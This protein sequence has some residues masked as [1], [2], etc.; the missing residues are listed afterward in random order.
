MVPAQ[1][2]SI[3][4]PITKHSL[5][6]WDR[7]KSPH[8][9]LLSFLNNPSFYPAWS[10]LS[11]FSAWSNAGLIRPIFF[12]HSELL[13]LF[14]HSVRCINLPAS[15]LFRYLQLKHLFSQTTPPDFT[16]PGFTT[17]ESSC[18]FDPHKRGLISDLYAHLFSHSKTSPPTYT[19]KWERDLNLTLERADWKQIWQST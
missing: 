11:S 1:C 19:N 12:L 5:T 10:S 13:H 18:K 7:L 14:P 4:N 9:P 2:L 3:T 6:I 8:N 16:T 15:E 17:F